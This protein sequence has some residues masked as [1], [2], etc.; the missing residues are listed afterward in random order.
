MAN[1][2]FPTASVLI[3]KCRYF[4]MSNSRVSCCCV[5][6]YVIR[7]HDPQQQQAN[8]FLSVTCSSP[9]TSV[10][11]LDPTIRWLLAMPPKRRAANNEPGEETAAARVPATPYNLRSKRPNNK[12]GKVIHEKC[13]NN[14]LINRSSPCVE[15]PV[16][17]G[18]KVKGRPTNKVY[19]HWQVFGKTTYFFF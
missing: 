2:A 19:F 12:P 15:S 6:S 18:K 5:N 8:G 1:G 14:D 17:G 10:D 16:G 11:P 9:T 7:S 3:L 4:I 13:G